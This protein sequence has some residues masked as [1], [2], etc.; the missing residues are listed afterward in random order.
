V[1]RLS[2]Q[3]ISIESPQKLTPWGCTLILSRCRA[4][5]YSTRKNQQENS[6][7]TSCNLSPESH[8]KRLPT[9][10]MAM[11]EFIFGIE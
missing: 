2:Q 9:S 1:K 4:A 11:T 10:D 3:T 7:V 8:W 6:R 5:S